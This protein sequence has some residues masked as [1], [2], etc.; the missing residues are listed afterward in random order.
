[1]SVRSQTFALADSATGPEEG[2][3]T[4][5][6][7][8]G[9]ERSRK[10][11][12]EVRLS[13]EV[14]G[15]LSLPEVLE[16]ICRATTVLVPSDRC[17]IYLWN[18]QHEALIP[19]AD[20]G[21]PAHL[22][23]RFADRRIPAE[24]IGFHL[25]AGETVVVSR[26]DAPT[27]EA[28][29]SLDE[30]ELYAMALV[31]LQRWGGT[32]GV[33]TLGLHAPPGFSE[34]ALDTARAVA[35]QAAQLIENAR[36]FTKI[37]K[38]AAF[39]AR[40]AELA[41]ALNAWND[42]AV[43]ARL[44][45]KRGAELFG[46]D[47]GVFYQRTGDA[48]V[49]VATAGPSAATGTTA[50]E[51]PLADESIPVV[52]AFREAR[53]VFANDVPLDGPD[54]RSPARELGLRSLLVVPFVG[55]AGTA[56]C[57]LYGDTKRHRAFSQGIADEGTLLAAVA[58]GAIERA[59]AAELA[60]RAVGLME[61]RNA[62]L[63]AAQMK[64]QFLANMSH[65]IRTPM[66]AMLGYLKLL[67]Q[68]A[69]TED[70]RRRHISTIQ[71]NGEHLLRIVNDILDLSKIEAGKMD[72]EPSPCSPVALLGEIV[73]LMRPRA[74]EKRLEFAVECCG[75]IPERIH[76][77]ATR[78]R[79]ILINLISN[80]IKFTPSG[81]VRLR[82]ALVGNTRTERPMLRFDVVDTGI[83]LSPEAIAKLFVPF[84]QADAS[85]ARRY[86]GTGLG[87]AISKRL[88]QML[89]GDVTVQ[90][91]FGE[92]STFSLTLETGSLDGVPMLMNPD[93]LVEAPAVVPLD[94]GDV[95]S[96]L[97]ARVLLAEDTP[98]IQ[99]LFAYYLET[100]GAT[101]EVA[102]NGLVACERALAAAAAGRPFDVI[103]MDMQMPELDGEEATRHLRHAGYAGP[104]IAVTAHA[105]QSERDRCLE[106]GCD[107]FLSKPVAPEILI[108][109]IRRTVGPKT[110]IEHEQGSPPLVSTLSG[111]QD[112]MRLLGLF[113]A[114]LP[115]RVTALE[116][117]AADGNLE[118][119]AKEAHQL[120]GTSASYGFMPISVVAAQLEASAKSGLLDAVRRQVVEVADLCRLAHPRNA[121][122]T[123]RP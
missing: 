90:S 13:D 44:V 103:L 118:A 42:R 28:A 59:Q 116:T 113:V 83:G 114:S 84:T 6:G 29:R 102:H 32:A 89:G 108:D 9:V 95:S 49:P 121:S 77:D 16:R 56:G 72:A 99:R 112:L 34:C 70:E 117:S 107:G 27:S 82:I 65:E 96:P 48:L 73:S 75:A 79:Q 58:S 50:P 67:S 45:C 22:V 37:Q 110:A 19:A 21:T 40:V 61:A 3:G 20:H 78:V 53:L 55:N 86:G 11:G 120:R 17:A 30:A 81:E 25:R 33:L 88:A 15:T 106:A 7:D 12:E 66:T 4:R 54:S 57:L 109:V 85:M 36:L 8:D 93:V 51:L 60:R 18:P 38:A 101:V 43:I 69:S 26:D 91:T 35:R 123:S 1:M 104:I 119:I 31:P 115:E 74:A 105:M 24:A 122:A 68:P 87:L 2:L 94:P 14:G 47:S 80:A 52:Q 111:G 63:A 71:Q 46:V 92:G 64:A 23:P 98:D 62:A 5:S 97:R 10:A 76:A 41:V 100:A 39:R